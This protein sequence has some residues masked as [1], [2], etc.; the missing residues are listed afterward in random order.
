MSSGRRSSR[1]SGRRRRVSAASICSAVT[2]IVAAFLGRWRR[3]SGFC[4]QSG[5]RRAFSGQ[6]A[7]PR[8]E[9]APRDRARAVGLAG[10][11][12]RLLV[13]G[14]RADRRHLLQEDAQAR[15]SANC[16]AAVYDA[17]STAL[18]GRRQWTKIRPWFE[19]A[20]PAFEPRS[21][22]ER[23]TPPPSCADLRRLVMRVMASTAALRPLLPRRSR[24]VPFGRI[25]RHAREEP[26]GRGSTTRRRAS[27]RGAAQAPG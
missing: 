18:L 4:I 2:P 16:G 12:V 15:R 17:R 7:E 8:L 22:A 6:R 5:S 19:V 13:A 20:A 21:G 27:R 9:S 25:L 3:V 10:H 11:L 24:L 1:S 26:Y 14:R 23:L